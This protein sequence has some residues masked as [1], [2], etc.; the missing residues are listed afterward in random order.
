M[1]CNTCKQS[2]KG[3]VNNGGDVETVSLLPDNLYDGSF[4][5]KVVAFFSILVA[6]PFLLVL[7][8]GQ[9]FLSFFFPKSLPKFSDKFK[10]FFMGIFK[11][12][13]EF[14][15]KRSDKK[16]Q[17]QFKKTIEYVNED[18]EEVEIY[19]NESKNDE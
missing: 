18:I 8:L 9:V 5:F 4:L 11:K 2:N 6:I 15:I 14:K 7:L 13:A 3:T 1:G 17:K 19:D 16:R 10:Q 12:Y